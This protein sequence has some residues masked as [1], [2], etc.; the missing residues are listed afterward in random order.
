MTVLTAFLVATISSGT[1]LLF[2]TLGEILTEKVGNLNLGVEGMMMMGAAFAFIVGMSTG[3]PGLAL[4]AGMAAGGG[5]ALI[6]AFLT[7]SLRANQVVTGLSLTIFGAGVADFVCK[8]VTGQ[9]L[10]TIVTGVFQRVKIPL[11]GDI[12]VIGEALFH[13]SI[14]VYFGYVIAV[15][16]WIYLWKTSAGLRARAVGENPGAADAGGIHVSANKYIHIVMGGML[17]GIAGAYLSL[18][19]S[20]TW[21]PGITGGMGWIAVALVIFSMWNP[22]RAI[23][24]A[25]IFGALKIIGFQF[26]QL[27][28]DI[29]AQFVD[30]LPYLVTVLVL[31][32]ISIRKSQKNPPP[33]SLGNEYFREKR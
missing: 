3:S 15:I 2:A 32:F 28:I 16:M 27:G 17:A 25:Y 12:P 7:V 21:Q 22:L 14:L 13:Q 30:M 10:P 11:I 9:T 24:G 33:G 6:Y 31:I 26:Q 4:L 18:Y 8:S 29:P 1:P 20:P 23:F 19:Y 5:G